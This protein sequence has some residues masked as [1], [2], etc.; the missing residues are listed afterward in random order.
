MLSDLANPDGYGGSF[1]FSGSWVR[2]WGDFLF[3]TVF[4]VI[5]ILAALPF[6]ILVV[7]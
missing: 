4:G 7:F 5:F 2:W 1:E 3:V 6:V